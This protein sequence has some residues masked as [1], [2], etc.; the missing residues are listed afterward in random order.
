MIDP[1]ATTLDTGPLS[2]QIHCLTSV[3]DEDLT[4]VTDQG[5]GAAR[6]RGAQRKN[7]GEVTT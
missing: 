3:V 6:R 5:V 2:G 7:G 4:A 1:L